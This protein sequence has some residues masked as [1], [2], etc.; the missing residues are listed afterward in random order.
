MM[1]LTLLLPLALLALGGN[2][3]SQVSYQGYTYVNT[4]PSRSLV[5]FNTLRQAKQLTYPNNVQVV[6][7]AQPQPTPSQIQFQAYTVP[8]QTNAALTTTTATSTAQVSY[9]QDT[10]NQISN[11]QNTYSYGLAVPTQPNQTRYS[12]PS[13]TIVVA[14][15]AIVPQ[16]TVYQQ[17]YRPIYQPAPQI[18]SPVV[19]PAYRPPTTYQAQTYQAPSQQMYRPVYY[20]QAGQS[21][22]TSEQQQGSQQLSAMEASRQLIQ[23]AIQ[24]GANPNN[25]AIQT[26][27]HYT[28][29]QQP[30]IQQPDYVAALDS[31]RGRQMLSIDEIMSILESAGKSAYFSTSS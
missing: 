28:I 12:A 14:P 21:G 11:G 4:A 30:N 7:Y 24:Q 10:N 27:S 20:G 13:V 16:P 3:R 18:Q 8:A 9:S 23:A 6:D 19:R 29:A 22:Q 2:V 31:Q 26:N 25:Y 1:D 5:G 15:A 17:P